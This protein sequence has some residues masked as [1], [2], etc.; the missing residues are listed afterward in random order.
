MLEEDKNEDFRILSLEK[1]VIS[2]KQDISTISKSIDELKEML[3]YLMT[4]RPLPYDDVKKKDQPISPI[5]DSPNVT[6]AAPDLS[7]ILHDQEEAE[8]HAQ[9]R[10]RP[11]ESEK[12]RETNFERNTRIASENSIK[13]ITISTPPDYSHI[14][15]NKLS[16]NSVFTF[17]NDVNQYENRHNVLLPVPALVNEN[18]RRR[19]LAFYGPRERLTET[20]YFRLSSTE[21]LSHLQGMVKPNSVQAFYRELDKNVSFN[22]DRMPLPSVQTFKFFYS[23]VLEY[24]ENFRKYVEFL[25]IDNTSCIPLCTYKQGDL[26]WLFLNK[27]P[28][29]YGALIW[30]HLKVLQKDCEKGKYTF[31]IFLRD[32]YK[33]LDESYNIALEAE[34]VTA[35]FGG[36]EIA[37]AARKQLSS[38]VQ[39]QQD[40]DNS[41]ERHSFEEDLNALL[42]GSATS[43]K[44]EPSKMPC[45]LKLQTGRCTKPGCKWLHESS[46]IHEARAKTIASLQELQKSGSAPPPR[47]AYAAHPVPASHNSLHLVTETHIPMRRMAAAYEDDASAYSSGEEN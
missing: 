46:A 21:L 37:S 22:S 36:T 33:T 26:L 11:K 40:D 14:V 41:D 42:A 5:I 6:F 28:Y 7:R 1:E 16:V 43:G 47:S 20:E 12:R 34:K 4:S 45:F 2:V 32:F 13:A 30:Q 44:I 17:F 9:V 29:S 38:L 25:S 8:Q 18:I 39:T 35:L 23:R 24:T 19:V 10:V 27:F 15:L 3:K 31:S